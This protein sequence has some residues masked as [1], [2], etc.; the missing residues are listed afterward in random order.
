[1]IFFGNLPAAALAFGFISFLQ[2]QTS[3]ANKNLLGPED[4]VNALKTTAKGQPNV[5]A[6]ADDV[7]GGEQASNVL[8]GDL[9]T[10]YF[11]KA[12]DG[13]TAGVNTGIVMSPRVGASVLSGFRIATA[14]DV[15]GR[16]PLAITIEGSNAANALEAGAAN[17]TLVHA[18]PTGLDNV[19][20][21]QKWGPTIAFKNAAAYR[22][23]RILVTKTR[24]AGGGAQYSEVELLGRATDPNT[25]SVPPATERRTFGP[26]WS[27]RARLAGAPAAGPGNPLV[28]WYREP[29]KVWEEAL[30]IGNG[31]L[32]AMVYGGISDERLQL[33]EDT[34]WDGYPL[35][36][37]NPEA[38]KALPKVQKLLFAGK[39]KEAEALAGDAMLGT[40]HGVKPYQSLG[41]LYIEIPG[42]ASASGY[43]RTLDLGTAIA[44]VR[45]ASGGATFRREMFSSAPAGVIAARFV[46]DRPGAINLKITL[47]RERDARCAAAPDDPRSILLEGRVARKDETGAE[48]GMHF[49]ARVSAIAEGG[50]VANTGGILTVSRANA[51]TLLISGA[52]SYPGLKKV[53]ESLAKDISG[54][55]FSSTRAGAPGPAA[56]CAAK[57]AAAAKSGY[58]ALRAEHIQDYQS[59]FNRVSL[60]LGP[61]NTAA[62][63][64]PTGERLKALKETGAEDPGLA[65]LYF[66]F[67]RY[68]LISSSR[69]GGLPA[70]LQGIWAWQMDPP[71][72]ADFHTN[73]NVQMNYWPAETTNLGELHGPLFDLMDS[74]VVPGAHVAKV[75]YGAGGWVVHHLTDPWGFTAPADGL[76]GVWPMGSAW[77]AR[78]P[79]EHYEFTGDKK[80]LAERAWPLMKGAAQ[81]ILDFLVEAPAGS[82][83][84]GKLVTN[85]SYS[86]E[87]EFFLPDG[88]KA[89]FTYGATMDLMIVR[90][91]LTNCIAASKILGVD[92]KLRVQCQ[93][94]LAKLAPVRVSPR[95]GRILEW[96]DDYQETDPHHRHTSHLY[97]LYPG[98][99]INTS[100][101]ELMAAA[102]K[103]LEARGDEGTGWGLAWKINMWTRL[104]DG[105]HAC[106]LLS[107]LL[108]EKTFPNLFDAHP[109]FQIDGNFGATAAI[110]EMLLQSQVPDGAEG[111]EVDLL[112]ALPGAWP[113]GSVSGLRARGE[114]TV[115][116]DWAMG[117]LT[118]ARILPG[119]SGKLKVRLGT[120]VKE[121]PIETGKMLTLDGGLIPR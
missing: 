76:Q 111:W 24:E 46:A 82:P 80:F 81:F 15:P 22:T 54:R 17:F 37:A 104:R 105:G 86:P 4:P 92:P 98:D 110:A 62:V 21:R 28:L 91:L 99:T 7:G 49:A 3:P 19:S 89:Q 20:D 8:D 43:L 33:N 106:V 114:V 115:A 94:A 39:N 79:W 60:T 67:G 14:N 18:G 55:S 47:R 26:N 108:R 119:R 35:D 51:V 27:D 68:L 31:R 50:S 77:L 65:A 11:N 107:N 109:P 52:T 100:T 6:A 93:A 70:N 41:E 48:R 25:S 56:I 75:Q 117:K 9:G 84:A 121:F 61:P 45:Y 32:G 85:P 30:P 116:L 120:V 66:Q 69:P 87:N 58:A 12:P 118:R 72:N 57:I 34:L 16:D 71:W 23:Y 97:G 2:A 29:A 5:L 59:Y 74:L 113:E 90:E 73:I 102:R 53:S 64:L 96:I 38:L 101:P 13:P 78:H 42:A 95:T 1:M 44:S 112:P 88:E 63:A 10:K 40:P 36:P 103:V 83:V